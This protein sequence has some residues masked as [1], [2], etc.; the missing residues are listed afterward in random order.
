MRKHHILCLTVVAE[1][2]MGANVLAEIV[3]FQAAASFNLVIDG[4][5]FTEVHPNPPLHAGGTAYLISINVL[6]N[7]ETPRLRGMLSHLVGLW[8]KQFKVPQVGVMSM[9]SLT[10]VGAEPVVDTRN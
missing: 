3:A 4:F 2:E 6:S 5:N 8:N 7:H 10:E 1:D 9:T